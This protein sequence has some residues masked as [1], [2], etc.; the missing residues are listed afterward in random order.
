M[1]ILQNK[2]TDL[3][4]ASNTEDTSED[5]STSMQVPAVW[6]DLVNLLLCSE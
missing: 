5:G 4:I 3:K 6:N 1:G 2:D